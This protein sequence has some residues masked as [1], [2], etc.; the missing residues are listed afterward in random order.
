MIT[1]ERILCPID[2]SMSSDQALRYAI[3]LARL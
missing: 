1:I 2:M 3:A